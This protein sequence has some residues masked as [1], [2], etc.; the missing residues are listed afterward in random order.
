[1][2][3]TIMAALAAVVF[4]AAARGSDPVGIYAL[5]DKVVLEPNDSRPERIRLYGVFV[6]GRN[7]GNE[8][9]PA[10]RGYMYFS[11]VEK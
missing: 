5:I 8:H 4:A 3:R 11:L 10:T 9:T 6:L 7:R 2:K 1:M